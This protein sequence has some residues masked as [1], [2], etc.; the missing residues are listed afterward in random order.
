V[1]AG[2]NSFFDARVIPSVALQPIL[3]NPQSRSS[4]FPS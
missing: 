2:K 1:T 3:E 4:E